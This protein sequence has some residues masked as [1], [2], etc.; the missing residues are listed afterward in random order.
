MSLAE[1]YKN[2]IYYY[3]LTAW[4]FN[5]VVYFELVEMLAV[6]KGEGRWEG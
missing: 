1:F 2:S 3:Q 4:K 6:S 5:N